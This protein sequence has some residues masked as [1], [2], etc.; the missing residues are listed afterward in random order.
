MQDKDFT[1]DQAKSWVADEAAKHVDAKSIRGRI[2]T[3]RKT[4]AMM[5]QYGMADDFPVAAQASRDLVALLEG[6]LA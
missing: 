2:D 4:Q 5:K 3:E 1:P 6:R